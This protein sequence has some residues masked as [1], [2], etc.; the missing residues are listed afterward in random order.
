MKRFIFLFVALMMCVVT[1]FT[2]TG[3]ECTGFIEDF[4]LKHL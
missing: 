2:Q 4:K 3:E 1:L